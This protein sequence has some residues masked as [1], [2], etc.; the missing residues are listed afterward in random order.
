MGFD[1][2]IV[3][4]SRISQQEERPAEAGLSPCSEIGLSELRHFMAGLQGRLIIL[5]CYCV[6]VNRYYKPIFLSFLLTKTFASIPPAS[7]RAI[8]DRQAIS[9]VMKLGVKAAI[10]P[11]M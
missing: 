3:G 4:I 8:K 1:E 9:A 10:S 6:I 11:K 5:G 2:R 7:M